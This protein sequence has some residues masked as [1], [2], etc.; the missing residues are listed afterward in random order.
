MVP[1]IKCCFKHSDPG[2]MR[3]GEVR[4]HRKAPQDVEKLEPLDCM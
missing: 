2:K 3:K 4:N 1:E